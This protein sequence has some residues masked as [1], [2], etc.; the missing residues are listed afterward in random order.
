MKR[1][2]S[3]ILLRGRR[4]LSSTE[5]GPVPKPKD[6][7][8]A[9]SEAL[10]LFPKKYLV[11]IVPLLSFGILTTAVINNRALKEFM[12]GLSPEYIDFVR[13]QYG[14]EEED[15]DEEQ[16]VQQVMLSNSQR[17]SFGSPERKQRAII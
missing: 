13:K 16:R 7:V 8:S 6:G 14:F 2:A 9:S 1:T 11:V 10:S 17:K 3:K 12:E 4:L 5:P 15:V